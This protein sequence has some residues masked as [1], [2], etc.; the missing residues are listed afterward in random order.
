MFSDRFD[1][2]ISKLI[3]KK[4]K[5]IVLMYFRAKNIL[6]NRYHTPKHPLNVF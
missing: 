2:L 1:M 6:K 5:N 3:F 4:W